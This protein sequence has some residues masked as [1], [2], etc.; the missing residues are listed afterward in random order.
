MVLYN[1]PRVGSQGWGTFARPGP[2]TAC[3]KLTRLPLR[4]GAPWPQP[5]ATGRLQA[6]AVAG[7]QVTVAAAPGRGLGLAPAARC[8][9]PGGPSCRAAA[10]PQPSARRSALRRPL[11]RRA[12]TGPAVAPSGRA[13]S[14]GGATVTVTLAGCMRPGQVRYIA[15][16]KS[17]AMRVTRQLRLPPRYRR[18]CIS[19]LSNR[20]ESQQGLPVGHR[21]HCNWPAKVRAPTGVRRAIGGPGAAKTASQ[22]SRWLH[23]GACCQRIE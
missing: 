1:W 21:G 7:V 15:R 14:G 13:A 2:G 6:E 16:P 12:A 22:L 8:L 3:F 4:Q 19:V 23:I 11:S 9:A 17:E 18:V 10:A 20:S 5:R